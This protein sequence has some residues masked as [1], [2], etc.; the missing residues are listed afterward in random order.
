MLL[1]AAHAKNTPAARRVYEYVCY[2][3]DRIT[4]PEDEYTLCILKSLEPR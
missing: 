2:E 3:Y 4:V 1:P